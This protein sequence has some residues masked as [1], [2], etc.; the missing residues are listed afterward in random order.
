MSYWFLTT[1]EKRQEALGYALYWARL[2]RNY[3]D[4]KQ[5]EVARYN[6]DRAIVLA[7]TYGASTAT[8]ANQ[9]GLSVNRIREI[10]RG[11]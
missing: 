7:H 5:R 3:R 10:V 11:G 1:A 9:T 8:L 6:R 2:A 4:P